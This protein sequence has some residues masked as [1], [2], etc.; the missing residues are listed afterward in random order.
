[1]NSIKPQIS[2]KK[3]KNDIDNDRRTK[4]DLEK[5]PTLFGGMRENEG[6][7]RKYRVLVDEEEDTILGQELAMRL[8]AMNTPSNVKNIV[9]N[10]VS[11]ASKRKI[12]C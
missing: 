7:G 10:E 8:V 1:M 6:I 2:D 11:Q 3:E 9:I 5:D 12:Y 4:N